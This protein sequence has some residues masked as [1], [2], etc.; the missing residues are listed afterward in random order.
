MVR[1]TI[2]NT[3]STA[4]KGLGLW[5][6]MTVSPSITLMLTDLAPCSQDY[7][8]ARR[9]PQDHACVNTP[10]RVHRFTPRLSALEDDL[11]EIYPLQHF[12]MVA[13]LSRHIREQNP[14]QGSWEELCQTLCQDLSRRST[15]VY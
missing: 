10:R 13:V 8:T 1:L 6:M 15:L 14:R 11:T 2:L 4:I 7:F 9:T 3:V 12:S 5:L